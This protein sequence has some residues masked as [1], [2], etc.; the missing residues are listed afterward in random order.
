MT[1]LLIG[2]VR[3]TFMSLDQRQTAA[4]R[5]EL[6]INLARS[7]QTSGGLADVTGLDRS[8][9]RAALQVDGARPEDVWL[10]RDYLDRVIRSNGGTP[11]PYS[12]LTEQARAAAR[13]WFPLRDIDAVLNG[14]AR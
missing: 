14:S 12:T 2:A 6:A 3:N 4:T 8:H 9:V 10:V 7:G 1:T 5:D 13:V 11:L